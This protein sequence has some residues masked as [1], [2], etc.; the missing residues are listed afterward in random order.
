MCGDG[1]SG[2]GMNLTEPGGDGRRKRDAGDEMTD[3]LDSYGFRMRKDLVE[4]V[5]K[6]EKLAMSN[7][8]NT[9]NLYKCTYLHTHV[10]R[11][12]WHMYF[13]TGLYF[14][15]FRKFGGVHKIISMKCLR[16]HSPTKWHNHMSVQMP[17]THLAPLDF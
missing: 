10:A 9:V 3:V 14:C 2:S 6:L 17:C 15:E 5:R 12:I 8:F 13:F 1:V 4:F 7:V 16:L 11:T